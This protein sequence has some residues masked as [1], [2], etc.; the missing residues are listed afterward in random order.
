MHSSGSRASGPQ[1]SAKRRSPGL[2]N[3][4][5]AVAYHFCPPLPAAFTQPGDHLV[6]DPM[7]IYV[8]SYVHGPLMHFFQEALSGSSRRPVVT[9]RGR[10]ANVCTLHCALSGVPQSGPDKFNSTPAFSFR[11]NLGDRK[12]ALSH[13]QVAASPILGTLLQDLAKGGFQIA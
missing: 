1:G 2:V 3:S 9:P 6:A 7:V 11:E 4:V 12:N 5:P 13:Y 8:T 10:Y